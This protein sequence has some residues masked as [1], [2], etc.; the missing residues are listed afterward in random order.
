MWI[1]WAISFHQDEDEK[2]VDDVEPNENRP[3][4]HHKRH[5]ER[6]DEGTWK[7]MKKEYNLNYSL[8]YKVIWNYTIAI[9]SGQHFGNEVHFGRMAIKMQKNAPTCGK[10]VGKSLELGLLWQGLRQPFSLLNV[11]QDGLQFRVYGFFVA[12]DFGQNFFRLLPST[13]LHQPHVRLRQEEG[14]FVHTEGKS[15]NCNI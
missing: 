10:V 5:Q 7:W 3:H 9:S 1:D 6:P 2:L 14:C 11:V 8:Y 12:P 4:A 13:S 15:I